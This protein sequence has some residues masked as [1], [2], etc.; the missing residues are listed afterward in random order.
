MNM[1]VVI[2][3]I[4]ALLADIFNWVVVSMRSIQASS[5]SILSTDTLTLVRLLYLG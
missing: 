3:N 4:A 1:T 5:R 2:I